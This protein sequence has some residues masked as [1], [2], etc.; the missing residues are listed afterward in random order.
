MIIESDLSD[1]DD[2]S[3]PGEP[4]DC[5]EVSGFEILRLVRVDARRGGDPGIAGSH[6][7][8]A[9][10]AH[11]V[12]EVRRAEE[13]TDAR[14]PCPGQ[15]LGPVRIEL[16]HIQMSVGVDECDHALDSE[17]TGFQNPAAGALPRACPPAKR[18]SR[19]VRL[20]PPLAAHWAMDIFR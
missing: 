15:D 20:R 13:G 7:Q 4:A 11:G 6:F 10:E 19:A 8:D 16:R 17:K 18:R 3:L 12:G 9:G 2:L 14:L 5:L 1:G